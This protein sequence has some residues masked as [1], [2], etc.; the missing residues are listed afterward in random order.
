MG[1]V[2]S[3]EAIFVSGQAAACGTQ[4]AGFIGNFKIL[5]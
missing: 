2:G 1:L 3:S 4:T 5:K